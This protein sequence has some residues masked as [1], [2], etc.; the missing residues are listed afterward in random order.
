MIRQ[1]ASRLRQEAAG[2]DT[3]FGT[4]YP[5]LPNAGQWRGVVKRIDHLTSNEIALWRR[6]TATSSEFRS[7][8]FSFEFAQAVARGGALARVCLLFQSGR[9]AGFFPFQFADRVAQL[10]AAGERIGGELNDF[11]G[12]IINPSRASRITV[13]ELLRCARLASV[14]VSHLEEHQPRFGL[15]G[16]IPSE[17]ARIKTEGCFGEYWRKIK[18]THRSM[19]DTLRNRERKVEREFRN[20]DFV[21][22]CEAP[23]KIL[24]AVLAEKKKQYES[25]GKLAGLAEPWKLRCLHNIAGYRDGRCMPVL[26]TLH[27]DGCWAAYH[28][29]IRSD[30]VLHY[31]FPV[32][33]KQFSNLSP[34][35]ILLAKMIHEAPSYGISEIDLG[36]GLSP[37]KRLFATESYSVYRDVWYRASPRGFAYRA[38]LS[39]VWRA[40]LLSR[41]ATAES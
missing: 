12:A 5:R 16:E 2:T 11:C 14:N 18:S 41:L 15:C 33:N 28:F 22:A 17:G 37:Y 4:A 10:M 27:F 19:Y 40:N 35:L 39:L 7:P 38:Y 9:L 24:D 32:Y 25:T 21:F 23:A 36:E 8:F 26:T 29:G 20:V 1:R 30:N 31:W 34:G 6:L 3:T 13:P